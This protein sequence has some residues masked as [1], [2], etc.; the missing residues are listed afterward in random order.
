MSEESTTLV[1]KQ[2]LEAMTEGI[3]AIALT[4]L[5]LELKLPPL[6]H[7]ATNA[8]LVEA[9]HAL[10]PKVL[11]WMLSF[12]VMV[13]LW[14]GQLRVYRFC[15]AL[16]WTL[17]WQELAMLAGVSL[18]PFSTALLGEYGNLPVAAAVYSANLLVVALLS[19]LRTWHLLRM[20]ELHAPGLTAEVAQRLRLRAWA[21][22]G[23]AAAALV[24]AFFLPGWNMLAMLPTA[25]LPRVARG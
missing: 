1:G 16:D 9:L 12:W 23:C 20:P 6:P 2:R 14:L 21:L 24:L 4:L 17:V 5:V 18:L 19:S 15:K 22:T 3:Y 7:E 13:L 8:A 25:L 10:L 11:T